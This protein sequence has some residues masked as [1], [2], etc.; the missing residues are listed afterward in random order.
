MTKMTTTTHNNDDELA[1][2]RSQ[3]AL[4]KQKLSQQN[5]VTE[6]LMRRV[7]HDTV[8]RILRESTLLIIVVLIATVFMTCRMASWGFPTLFVVLTDVMIAASV[9][10]EC[11]ERWGMHSRALLSGD[12]TQA[13]RKMAR[14]VRLGRLS[15]RVS[16][17]VLAVW[18][19]WLALTIFRSQHDIGQATA[20]VIGAVVGGIVGGLIGGWAYKRN[21]RRATQVITQIDHLDHLQDTPEDN[22]EEK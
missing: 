5:I 9:V 15:M 18:F 10:M 2:M 6:Q 7:M 4:L 12:L 21:M 11:V 3:M 14:Y 8:R 19:A 13:S 22:E 1:Q 20:M 17:P 16:I